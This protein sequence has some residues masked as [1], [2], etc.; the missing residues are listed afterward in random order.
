M[1]VVLTEA[2]RVDLFDAIEWYERHSEGT[3]DRFVA[4]Y[5]RVRSLVAESPE[6]WPR[7]EPT[8]HHFVFRDF[9]YSLV[10]T[11][12]EDLVMVLAV[13]HHSRAPEYWLARRRR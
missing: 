7:I 13:K 4:E 9:P 11:V 8:A 10:Y 2:A 3:A 12:A 5:R 1:R 6:R